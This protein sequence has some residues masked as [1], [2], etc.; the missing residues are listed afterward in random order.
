MGLKRLNL[1][2]VLHLVSIIILFESVF[3]L[4]ALV[5]S[6]IYVEKVE[7]HFLEAFLIS[8]GIGGAL[9]WFTKKFKHQ[10]PT[11]QESMAVAVLGWMAMALIGTLPYLVTASIPHFADALF[12]SMSGFTT[13]GSSILTDIEALPKSILFWRSLTHWIGGMGIVVLVVAVMSYIKSSGAQLFSNE[14]SVVVE[15][16]I[17]SRIKTIARQAWFIY[18]GL[19]LIETI[20]LLFGGMDLFDAICHSFATVATGGFSTKNSSITDFSPYIQYVITIFMLL[21]GINFSLHILCV[22]KQFKKALRNEEMRAYLGIIGVVTF[23]LT[24]LLYRHFPITLEKA[25]RDSFFQV[26]SIIT[27]TG[28]AT[29]DYLIWPIQGIILIGILMFI[30]ASAGSTGGGIKVIRHV[31]SFKYL[32]NCINQKTNPNAVYPVKY[33]GKVISEKQISGI[34]TF[35]L[36]YYSVV[37]I[38][39]FVMSVMGNSWATSF[40]SVLT[41]MGGMGPGFGLVGPASNFSMLSDPSKYFLCF[42]MLLGRL[43]IFPVIALFSAWFWKK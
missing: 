42:T 28:F 41:T 3:M 27:A 12:E 20:L 35:V 29:A 5:V 17:S 37:I 6:F 39:T 26:V 18:V 11:S 31:I 25:F 10:E 16:K 22:H 38:G 13:T 4:L 40:G 19:T 2:I 9:F 24:V 7:I 32:R 23:L 8:V 36:I 21:S 34:I 1:F 43:E 14:A 15:E 30:G 33:N